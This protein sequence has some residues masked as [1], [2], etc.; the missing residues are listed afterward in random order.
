[1]VRVV[2]RLLAALGKYRAEVALGAALLGGWASLAFG[3]SRI[4]GPRVWPFAVAVLLLS[5]AG[6]RFT[7]RLVRDGLYTL[8]RPPKVHPD[9]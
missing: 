1:M 4:A 3:L 8:T 6:W 9:A 7:Y 2:N 5:G